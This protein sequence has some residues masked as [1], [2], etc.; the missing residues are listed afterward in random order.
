MHATSA[1]GSCKGHDVGKGGGSDDDG[2]RHGGCEAGAYCGLCPQGANIVISSFSR[3]T[4]LVNA[5]SP[6]YPPD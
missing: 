2:G 1:N 6:Y 4:F 5:A 3:L